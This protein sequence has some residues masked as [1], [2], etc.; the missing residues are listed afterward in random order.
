MQTLTIDT[1]IREY[2]VNNR[3]VLRFNP[4]DPNL[5]HRFFAAGAQL[6]ALDKEAN[7]ALQKA[8]E[9]SGNEEETSAEC[10]RILRSYDEKIK[11]LLGE[12]FGAE[13]DFDTILEGVSLAGVGANGKRVVQNLLD[14]LTPILQ[15]GAQQHLAEVT[16]QARAEAAAHRAARGADTT[17]G[18]AAEPPAARQPSAPGSANP[19]PAT[20]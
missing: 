8:A 20:P 15:Q 11:R 18:S 17:A 4:A 5:Y 13:N 16:A 1:G 9:S 19:A 14:A 2:R 12:I 10:L 3:G 7:A 6:D